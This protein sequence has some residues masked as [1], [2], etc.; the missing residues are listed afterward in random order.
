M[1]N[2]L[3]E[4]HPKTNITLHKDIRFHPDMNA[5]EKLFYAEIQSWTEEKNCPISS[6]KLSAFFGVSH[7][8]ILNWIEKLI[9][10]DLIEIGANYSRKESRIFMKAK[11]KTET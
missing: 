8:T 1:V 9:K 11:K 2:L 7:Q 4:F 3:K 10:L 6:R 5:G